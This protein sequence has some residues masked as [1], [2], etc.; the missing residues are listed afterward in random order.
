MPP[1]DQLPARIAAGHRRGDDPGSVRRAVTVR[2]DSAGGS[3]RLVSEFRARNIG[4]S[5]VARTNPQVQAAISRAV[6]DD[7]RWAPSLTQAGERT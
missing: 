4:F 3:A 1:I 7:S 6:D 5:V 2:A